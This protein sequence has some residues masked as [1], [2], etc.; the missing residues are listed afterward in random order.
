MF[1]AADIIDAHDKKRLKYNSVQA[2][3][4]HPASDMY[5]LALLEKGKADT[6]S[7]QLGVFTGLAVP[8]CWRLVRRHRSHL[9]PVLC[10][11][12]H[13][14]AVLS[15]RRRFKSGNSLPVGRQDRMGGGLSYTPQLRS[16]L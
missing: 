5:G 8:G 12:T 15:Q 7:A 2:F 9:G 1:F 10:S 16:N 4:N 14:S 3:R 6:P 13:L 11:R